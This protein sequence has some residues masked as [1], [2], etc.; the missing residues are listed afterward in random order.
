MAPAPLWV[1]H[2][3]TLKTPF[4][5]AVLMASAANRPLGRLVKAPLPELEFTSV[6]AM[7]MFAESAPA[8]WFTRLR[9]SR[10][11]P[12]SWCT[13]ASDWSPLLV[14]GYQ[15]TLTKSMS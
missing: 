2:Q 9:T 6:I 15:W 13:A 12:G 1:S 10:S 8:Y 5:S 14:L 3:S 4:S 7:P 11:S